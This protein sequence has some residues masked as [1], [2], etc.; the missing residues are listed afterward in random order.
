[1]LLLPLLNERLFKINLRESSKCNIC[2]DN[3]WSAQP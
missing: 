2:G 3:C 1:M